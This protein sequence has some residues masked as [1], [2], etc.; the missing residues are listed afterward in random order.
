MSS[1]GPTNIHD[2]DGNDNNHITIVTMGN[3][4][5]VLCF[6]HFCLT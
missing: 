3:I 1:Y 5:W 4:Y 6:M 2:D